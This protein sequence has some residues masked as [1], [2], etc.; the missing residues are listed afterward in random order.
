MTRK[1]DVSTTYFNCS[2]VVLNNLSRNSRTPTPF[3]I[4]SVIIKETAGEEGTIYESSI[5]T[6]SQNTLLG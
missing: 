6:A 2:Q 3:R 1:E 4:F 5:V